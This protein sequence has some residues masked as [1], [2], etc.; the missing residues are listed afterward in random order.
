MGSRNLIQNGKHL[1]LA[2]S[3]CNHILNLVGNMQLAEITRKNPQKSIADAGLLCLVSWCRESLVKLL[4]C[5]KFRRNSQG[6]HQPGHL[7]K[8]PF[9]HCAKLRCYRCDILYRGLPSRGL[10]HS[11]KKVR[12]ACLQN[13]IALRSRGPG[14]EP[15]NP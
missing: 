6:R 2:I 14:K 7:S 10:N 5:L 12:V 3:L 15:K 1:S 9:R 11:H 13:E 4:R 8:A